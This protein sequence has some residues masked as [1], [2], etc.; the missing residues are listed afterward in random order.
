MYH[1]GAEKPSRDVLYYTHVT[2]CAKSP[3]AQREQAQPRCMPVYRPTRGS[4]PQPPRSLECPHS[5]AAW[6]STP[7]VPGR[8]A[9]VWRGGQS[10]VVCPVTGWVERSGDER[11]SGMVRGAT[12]TQ[13]GREKGAN[14]GAGW[15]GEGGVRARRPR[16]AAAARAHQYGWVAGA[17]RAPRR[18][19]R[20]LGGPAA[21]PGGRVREPRG[22]TR[23]A[24]RPPSRHA[25]AAPI[26][27]GGE[28]ARA[29]WIFELH[30]HRSARDGRLA[31]AARR[32]T[33]ARARSQ[34]G[35][36]LRRGHRRW[37]RGSCLVAG[38]GATSGTQS[39]PG[40]RFTRPLLAG[41]AARAR[42]WA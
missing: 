29:N 9:G 16:R 40:G 1:V 42:Y 28:R 21:R 13:G 23:R 27:W 8:R 5:R 32:H 6:C 26:R 36:P 2:R 17:G 18:R 34:C 33:R 10:R 38:G 37:P 19:R 7:A 39:A 22:Q 12:V 3:H 24:G 41:H 15:G 35:R 30:R 11:V 25:P 14:G 20:R 4:K 31:P